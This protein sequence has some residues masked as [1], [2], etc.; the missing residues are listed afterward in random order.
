MDVTAVFLNGTISEEVY[1]KQLEE[2]IK[3]GKEHLVCKLKHS[4]YGLK[5]STEVL[6]FSAGHKFEINGISA[7]K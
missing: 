1:M 5:T 4:L 3:E 7:V 6:E 2:F